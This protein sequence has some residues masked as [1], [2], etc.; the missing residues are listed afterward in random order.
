[1]PPSA[2]SEGAPSYHS[3]PDGATAFSSAPPVERAWVA[4]GANLGDRR[5]TLARAL[6]WLAALPETRLDA[7]SSFHRTT[8][9]VAGGGPQPDYLNAV[10][11]LV[12]RL[13]PLRLLAALQALEAAA[14]RVR[15]ERWGARTLDLDLLLMGS[16]VLAAPALLL[17]H[18]RMAERAFVLA[19]LCE[20]DPELVHPRLGVPMAELLRRARAVSGA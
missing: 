12:T 3:D 11:R 18:P 17:P 2:P 5:A 8:A 1:M 7:V 14:G 13:A 16:R 19:P 4:L 9:L 20:L 15:R 6:R 10:A